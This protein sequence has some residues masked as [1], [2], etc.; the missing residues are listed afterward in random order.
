M[1]TSKLQKGD[2]VKVDVRGL[3]FSAEYEGY[4]PKWGMHVIRPFNRNI[5]YRCVSSRRIVKKLGSGVGA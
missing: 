4:E 3:V 5:S 2:R 1:D